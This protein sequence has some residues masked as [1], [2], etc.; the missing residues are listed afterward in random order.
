MFT[1]HNGDCLEYMKEVPKDVI[2]VTDPP[3]GIDWN[4]NYQSW[5]KSSAKMQGGN[6][7]RSYP[8]L[9]NDTTL[10]DIQFLLDFPVVVI[11]GVTYFMD[12]LGKGSLL[13][14]HKRSSGFLADA[15][16]A[17]MNKGGGVF[18]Y[19][20]PVEKMQKDRVHP[21][22]KPVEVMRWCIEK[23]SKEGDTIF[24]PFMGSGSTGVAALQLGRNF[25]GCEIMP[26]YFAMAEKR[27]KSA[28]FQPGLFTPSNTALTQTGLAPEGKQRELFK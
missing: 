8:K 2:V 27:V 13:I 12:V 17:W 19:P 26:E 15:E 21:T 1:L 6:K 18:V 7:R 24:D 22:Q 5:V 23:A 14:W 16:A 4:T 28:V 20:F 25:I 10:P 3:Y 9:Q 11:W